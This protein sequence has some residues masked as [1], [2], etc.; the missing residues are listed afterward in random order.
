MIIAK[1]IRLDESLN[2]LVIFINLKIIYF[3]KSNLGGKN[4][5]KGS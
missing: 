4:A 1:D 3:N 2:S 5:E